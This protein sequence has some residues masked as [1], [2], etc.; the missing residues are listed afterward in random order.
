MFSLDIG[1]K[2]C[3]A[4]PDGQYI[5]ALDSMVSLKS[6]ELITEW[7]LNVISIVSVITGDE[8]LFGQ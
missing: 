7:F 4:S 5:V 6:Q 8:C 2:K 1:F 3:L